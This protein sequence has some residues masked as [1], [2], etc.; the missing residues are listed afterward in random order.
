MKIRSANFTPK[1][2]WL[3]LLLVVAT[4][5]AYWPVFSAGFIWDDDAYVTE[6]P[7]LTAPDGLW[8]IW[9]SAHSQSQYF[10]LVFTTLRLE[11]AL[12]GL[13][14]RWLSR[15][16]CRPAHR[17][18]A[19]GLGAVAAAGAAGRVAGGGDFRAASGAGGNRGVGDGTEKHRV[20]AVLPAGGVCVA[21]FLR[22]KGRLVLCAGAGAAPLALFAKT[23]A[24]TLPAAMLLVLWLK[25]E[26]VNWRRILQ[27]LPFLLLGFGMGLLSVWWE[28]HLGNYQ[29]Q[30]HLLGGPLDRLID[31]HARAVVLCRE[32]FLAGESDVQLIRAGTSSLLTGNN[33]SGS[34]DVC[35]LPLRSG[36]RAKNWAANLE[37]RCF[38]SQ[39]RY[40]R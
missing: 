32:D 5:A 2:L 31:S 17:Q 25:N 14:S 13:E 29:P 37:R 1:P 21:A 8:R 22:G 4:L 3:G 34:P 33:F 35:L 23:T 26:P 30:F 18:R 38:F 16:Q 28:N 24:C 36:W 20:H 19:A 40:R 39:R 27:T 15:R 9:F 12:V 11:Y 10:P 6:N 7:L